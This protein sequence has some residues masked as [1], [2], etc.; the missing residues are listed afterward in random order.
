M[1]LLYIIVY[2]C[3]VAGVAP[4]LLLIVISFALIAN[5]DVPFSCRQGFVYYL[6]APTTVLTNASTGEPTTALLT[7]ALPNH[8]RRLASYG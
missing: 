2:G 7:T 1:G 6:F 5:T 8:H 3:R 4:W